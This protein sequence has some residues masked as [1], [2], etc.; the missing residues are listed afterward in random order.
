ME[1]GFE[2][3]IVTPDRNF[4]KGEIDMLIVRTTEGDMGVLRNH[5]SFVAPLSVGCLKIKIDD[6]TS[7]AACSGGF[8]NIEENQVTIVTDSAEWA[9]EIDVNR[10]KEAQMRA[11]NRMKES[12]KDIDGLRVKMALYRA[13]NRITVAE[14]HRDHH[15]L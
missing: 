12:T 1:K 14:N 8:I 6:K 3:T 11:E 13:V 4:Y 2:L 7:A 9:H 15:I 10:A 5:E